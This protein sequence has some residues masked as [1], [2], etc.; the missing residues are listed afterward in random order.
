MMKEEQIV[1]DAFEGQKQ[2]LLDETKI[3]WYDIVI[4]GVCL[5]VFI[6]WFIFIFTLGA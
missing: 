5:S 1:D 3:K 6:G 2:R 4:V